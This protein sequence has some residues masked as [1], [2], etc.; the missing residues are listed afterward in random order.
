MVFLK[1][2]DKPLHRLKINFM[3]NKTL[4]D[5]K[6]ETKKLVIELLNFED[7]EVD[8]IKDDLSLLSGE[9]I[10][11]ID[12]IDVLEVVSAIQ[13]K[14]DVQI[15]DINHAKLI[16]NTVDTIADFVYSEHH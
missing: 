4:D 13:T 10:I 14:F 9:N 15:L 8:E 5:I 3:V 12:S 11:T 2:L 6:I 7:V 1:T 16:I